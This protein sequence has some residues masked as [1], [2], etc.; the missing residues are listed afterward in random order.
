[1]ELLAPWRTEATQVEHVVCLNVSAGYLEF[2]M[3]LCS[4]TLRK[5][6]PSIQGTNKLLD[7]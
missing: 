2:K 5:S 1:M 7:V 4:L 6:L 3:R